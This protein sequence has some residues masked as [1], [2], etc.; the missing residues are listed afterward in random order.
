[1]KTTTR[2]IIILII[3]F[4]SFSID[5]KTLNIHLFQNGITHQTDS[6]PIHGALNQNQLDQYYPNILDTIIDRRIIGAEPL[7]LNTRNTFYVSFLHNTGTADQIFLCTH[8]SSFTLIDSYYIGKST[9][10]DKTSLTIDYKLIEKNTIEFNQVYWGWV[11]KAEEQ[12]IDTLS[13]IKYRLYINEKGEIIK[14]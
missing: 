14:K 7:D 2:Y 10:F 1:M 11:K 5:S 3:L 9:M 4:L 12:E 8:D 13:C 6:L